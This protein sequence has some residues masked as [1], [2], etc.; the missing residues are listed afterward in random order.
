MEMRPTPEDLLPATAVAKRLGMSTAQVY[1]L[2]DSGQLRARRDERGWVYVL[3][4]D[5][6]RIELG[7]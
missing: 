3:A 1:R 4:E 6:D 7:S 5:L 2:I